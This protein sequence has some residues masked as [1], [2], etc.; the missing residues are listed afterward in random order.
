L[1]HFLHIALLVPAVAS[2]SVVWKGDFETGNLSQWT[3]AQSV[4]S[5][6]LQVV[7]DVVREGSYALKTTVHQGDDPINASGNRNEVVY[8]TDEAPGT[9]YFYKWST[10]FPEDYPSMDTWQLFAQWHQGGCCG[11]PPLE[12]YVVG[13]AMFMRVGGINGQVLWQSPLVRGHWNDFVLHV[14]WSSDPSVGF[15]EMYKDGELVVPKTMAA[16]QFS[17]DR[18]YLKLGLYRN[19]T[20]SQVGVVYH[21]GFTM[22]TSLQ[23]VM[24]PPP[25]PMVESTPTPAPPP[26][27]QVP[28]PAST[29]TSGAPPPTSIEPPQARTPAPGSSLPQ[30][31]GDIDYS[32]AQGCGASASGGMPLVAAAALLALA[33]YTRRRRA[34]A[35]SR[36]RNP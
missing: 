32:Q 20:I 6:R 9:E 16:T 5:D 10:L 2:A 17:G 8:M 12:F 24:P 28:V 26:V 30:Q 1:K 11:S 27:A 14:K 22:G 7:S 25:P 34:L 31:P 4:A 3:R 36:A 13:E 29:P 15:V 21:D 33:L 18:N 19:D 23:D 35:R